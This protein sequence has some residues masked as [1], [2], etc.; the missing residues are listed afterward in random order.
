MAELGLARDR[1]WGSHAVGGIGGVRLVV[2]ECMFPR[3]VKGTLI[4][5]RNGLS[6]RLGRGWASR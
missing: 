4:R 5:A 1:D 2:R 3:R 6:S